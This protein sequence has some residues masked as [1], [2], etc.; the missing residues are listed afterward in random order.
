MYLIK[1]DEEGKKGAAFVRRDEL[2]LQAN[3]LKMMRSEVCFGSLRQYVIYF[4]LFPYGLYI[5]ILF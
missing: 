1:G 4:K 3:C 2:R 5:Y